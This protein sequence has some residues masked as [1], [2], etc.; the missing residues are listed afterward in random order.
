MKVNTKRFMFVGIVILIA[1]SCLAVMNYN[2]DRLSR[3][4]YQD[5]KAREIINEYFSDRDIAYLI[6]Y[7][8]APSEFIEYVPYPGF[9]VY[10][11]EDYNRLKE[12]IWYLDAQS[13]VEFVELTRESIELE[14]LIQLLLDYD[15]VTIKN[16]F[17]L[18][19][20]S[21]STLVENPSDLH[22]I[23]DDEHT[24]Y[25]RVLFDSLPLVSLPSKD[26]Q[27]YVTSSL[28]EPVKNMCIA[29]ETELNN[30]M[31]CGGLVADEGHISYDRQ[32]ELFSEAVKTYG[33]D[34]KLYADEAGHSEHQLGLALDFSVS[35]VEQKDFSKT[36]QYEW[37]KENAHR[38]GF[39]QSYQKDKEELLGKKERPWHWRYVGYDTAAKM[40]YENLT[41]K[42][43]VQTWAQ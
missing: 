11:S 13:I 5:E 16:Y 8:I 39:V 22:A 34:A 18:G 40:H 32:A 21:S 2:Y 12:A 23:V 33:E 1:V 31:T 19:L 41:L 30:G 29:I 27:V 25:T 42:E 36:I 43:V 14:D 4:P 28:I 24:L 37:L 26:E 10:H 7:S 20:D 15:G 3:Y 6:E 35:H 38:F 9:S 17:T